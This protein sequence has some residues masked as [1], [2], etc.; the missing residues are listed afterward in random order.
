MAVTIQFQNNVNGG[1]DA[2]KERGS[3]TVYPIAN[4]SRGPQITLPDGSNTI[5]VISDNAAKEG[6][7]VAGLQDD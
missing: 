2:E 3:Q 7:I 1:L 5:I 4:G 6:G